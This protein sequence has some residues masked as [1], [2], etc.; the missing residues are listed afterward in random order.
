MKKINILFLLLLVSFSNSSFSEQAFISSVSSTCG[1]SGNFIRDNKEVL[2][3]CYFDEILS[4]DESGEC[5]CKIDP[6]CQKECDEK[7][8][9]GEKIKPL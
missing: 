2:I 5:L 6:V 8:N 9:C 7:G 1:D 3:S 4:C